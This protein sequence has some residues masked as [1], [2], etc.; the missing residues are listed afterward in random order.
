MLAHSIEAA[1]LVAGVLLLHYPS[2]AALPRML[3]TC[4]FLDLG[5]MMGPDLLRYALIG[6]TAIWRFAK[7]GL[8]S[9]GGPSSRGPS[10]SGAGRRFG[11]RGASGP[12][13]RPVGEGAEG[14]AAPRGA[15][16]AAAAAR[17][18]GETGGGGAPAGAQRRGARASW[19]AV[20]SRPARLRTN[21]SG[22][23]SGE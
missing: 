6:A 13:G 4:Y 10:P 9:V 11:M 19:G 21:D 22:S 8:P 7:G 15:G 1:I 3:V 17:R 20:R 23:E 18:R 14:A 12:G 16:G 2:N 5:F